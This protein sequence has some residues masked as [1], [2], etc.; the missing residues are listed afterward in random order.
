MRVENIITLQGEQISTL[1]D[2]IKMLSKLV[3]EVAVQ[4]NRL[5]S[6]D[7]R[8]DSLDRTIEDLRRGEGMIFPLSEHLRPA[9]K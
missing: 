6:Q 3:T 7:K 2:E 8:L 1:K 4:N 5:D 9:R